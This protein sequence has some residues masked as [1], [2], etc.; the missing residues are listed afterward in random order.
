VNVFYV[1]IRTT[2]NYEFD[3]IRTAGPLEKPLYYKNSQGDNESHM[4][5][6][7]WNFAALPANFTT[8]RHYYKSW[9]QPGFCKFGVKRNKMV[10]QKTSLVGLLHFWAIAT[11]AVF[12]QFGCNFFK[13]SI[14]IAEWKDDE[15]VAMLDTSA[16]SL[17]RNTMS[18]LQ[19]HC[20]DCCDLSCFL[21]RFTRCPCVLAVV[22]WH[23]S[24]S[25]DPVRHS[26]SSL[27]SRRG[28]QQTRHARFVKISGN[29]A[30]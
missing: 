3:K 30:R 29:N 4:F 5:N 13:N 24:T 16:S 15:C 7:R 23:C 1:S 18:E 17:K 19:S 28:P 8:S 20:V 11:F 9:L 21:L 6:Q 12:Q 25:C 26:S 22:H 10:L 2:E 14:L 27:W